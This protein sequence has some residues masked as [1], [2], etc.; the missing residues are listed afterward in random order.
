MAD[1]PL[2]YSFGLRQFDP[3]TRHYR[4]PIT[5]TYDSLDHVLTETTS[6]GTVS[7]T[8]DTA[9]RRTSMTVGTQ[10]PVTYTYDANAQLLPFQT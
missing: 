4:R 3:R 5:L 10:P 2:A 9:G 8:Y 7:Y 6:L 1:T